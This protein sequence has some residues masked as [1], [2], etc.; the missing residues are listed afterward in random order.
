MREELGGA[1]E[2][3]QFFRFRSPGRLTETYD[4]GEFSL[5]NPGLAGIDIDEEALAVEAYAVGQQTA[6]FSYSEL[7]GMP[8]DVYEEIVR[9][10]VEINRK[11]EGD[12]DG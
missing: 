11:G 4:R 1:A 5:L 9:R 12:G 2:H 7:R 8:L 10:T 3:L 6:A